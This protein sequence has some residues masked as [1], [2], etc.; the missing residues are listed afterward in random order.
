MAEE[1]STRFSAVAGTTRINS[2]PA[3]SFIFSAV[4]ATTQIEAGG[5]IL[6][7]LLTET[8]DNLVQE[9]GGRILLDGL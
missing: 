5:E 3:F 7:G 9:D 8:S 2:D 6:P 1:N 4:S